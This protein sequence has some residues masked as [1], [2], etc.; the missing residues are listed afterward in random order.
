MNENNLLRHKKDFRYISLDTET[1][2][3]NPVFNRPWQIGWCITE[4]GQIISKHEYHI[5]ISDLN[6]SPDAARVTKFNMAEH[7]KKAQD[8][9]KVYEL[10]LNDFDDPRNQ[11]VAQNFYFDWNIIL[12]LAKYIGVQNKSIVNNRLY[13]TIALSKA[14]RLGK[15]PPDVREE[16]V[17][18]QFSMLNLRKKGL[19]TSL[20]LMCREFGI[21][22][23]DEFSHSALYDATKTS[24]L[25]Q[26]LIMT[27]KV[28]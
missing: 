17:N 7:L 11:I 5:R 13:D 28:Y 10:F 15:S 21:D 2:N 6:V 4:G 27:V 22:F 20:G 9:R 3:L 24:E 19:K 16:Y 25:F 8:P 14:Y 12:N 26:K 23:S 18:W 1:E